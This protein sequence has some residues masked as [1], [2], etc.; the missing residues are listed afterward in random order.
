MADPENIS[1]EAVRRLIARHASPDHVPDTFHIIT[2]T[3]D[4]FQVGY[5]HVLVLDENFY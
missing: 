1:K 3:S 5:N 2:D 4:F